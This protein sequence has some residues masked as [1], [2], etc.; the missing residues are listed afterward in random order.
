MAGKW[1]VLK[2]GGTSVA[3]RPQWE[4]IASLARARRSEGFRVLLVC[5]AVAGITDSL[6][7]LANQPKS[8]SQLRKIIDRHR[9]LARELDVDEQHWLPR[10]EEL[11]DRWLGRLSRDA[12]PAGRA[13]LLAMGEWLSTKIGACFLNAQMETGW[14]DAREALEVLEEKELSSARQW[15]SASCSAGEDPDLIRRWSGESPVLITQGFIGRTRDGETALL[16]R[17]GSDTSAALLAGRLAA[18]RLEVWTDVP[19]LFSADPR[20]IHDARLLTNVDYTEALEMAA[21][22]AKVV[23]ARAIRAATVT[24]TPVIIRDVGR[25]EVTG[26]RIGVVESSE[27]GIKTVTCQEDMVVI[28]LQNLDARHQVGFLAGVFGVF[29]HRG[30]SVDLVATSETTTTVAVNRK[31]N[32]L[33]AD[34]LKELAEDL[35]SLC[36]VDL[37]CNCVCV[38]LVG[39][40]AR[41][42]LSR[43]QG[44]MRYFDDHP[45]LM[46]SQSANDLCISL[47][48][49]AG[50]HEPLLKGAHEALIPS[51][52]QPAQGVFGPSWNE[53]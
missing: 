49:R 30:I 26:T 7:A 28:L 40:G 15:L 51:A 24:R 53:L 23:H 50:D 9:A 41:G 6:N 25:L 20:L 33:D 37:F 46:L 4:T 45:L 13:A 19:G 44:V 39:R 17:G 12:G 22:G 3:G 35:R 16:G 31:A 36:K 27:T 10:A 29:S 47:L 5:S 48:V 18:E 1:I 52:E 42:A 38:N 14:V 21:S 32:H 34:G 2:F 8:A 11:L 43:L